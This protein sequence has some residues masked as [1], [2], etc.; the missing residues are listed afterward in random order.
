[1]QGRISKW[2]SKLA[3]RVWHTLKLPCR[4]LRLL[5]DSGLW[6][7]QGHPLSPS[8]IQRTKEILHCHHALLALPE[9][10]QPVVFSGLTY[11]KAKRP[12]KDRLALIINDMEDPPAKVSDIGCQIG[13]FSFSLAERGYSVTGYDMNARNI[14]ICHMLNGLSHLSPKPTFKNIA[15]I[16]ETAE[17]FE[18]A[19]YTLCLAV[20]HHIIYYHGLPVAQELV[21]VLRNKTRKKLYFE[22]GQSNEP[23]EPWAKDMPDMGSDPI[24]WISEFLRN[25]GFA[26]VKVLGLVPTH[27][28]NVPRYLVVAS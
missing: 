26:D 28:S 7:K 24:V 17:S 5:L 1:M 12:C 15:L 18:A 9:I 13:F 4:D 25:G 22:I 20:F 27:V 2:L 19:D 23:V 8:G 3:R 14:Q 21:H 16:P 11:L 10:Y 6:P